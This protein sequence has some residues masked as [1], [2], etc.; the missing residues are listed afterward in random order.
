MSFPR[1]PNYKP[2]G[3]EWLGEVPEHWAIPPLYVRYEVV[4]GKMLDTRKITGEFLLPYIRNIDVQWD[5]INTIDLPEIDIMPDE[6]CRYTLKHGDLVVCEGGEVGRSA[7]WHGGIDRC[8]FQKAIHRLRPRSA[9]EVPRYLF[10]CMQFASAINIFVADGNPN[11][12]AHLTSEKFKLYRLPS[13]PMMEQYRIVAFLDQETAK[14][15]A[16][17]AE[18]QRLI[19]LLKE[20]RQAVI[21]H[22]VTKGL[23]PTVP[24]KPSGIE[25]LGDIPAH[26]TLVRI[27]HLA[28]S[29]EQGWSPQCEGFPV[30]TD[31][32]W[33]VL[34][35]GC[36]N[37]GIF[38][39]LEN[40]AL[41][42]ELEPVPSLSISAGDLLVSRANTR[43]LVGSSA[44]PQ[45]NHPNLLLCDKI[46]RIKLHKE[47][48]LPEFVSYYLGCTPVRGQIELGATGASSS[49]VNIGQSIILEL[50]IAIA[51]T[52]EQSQ[53]LSSIQRE[54][55]KL[56]TLTAEAERAIEL[57]QERRT[58]LISAAVTGQIDVRQLA[59]GVAA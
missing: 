19:E 2:S 30:E 59:Q 58:A 16:L 8:A 55:V 33:G 40:K 47:R 53:I 43:E 22:A 3:V 21:S 52:E 34:K 6:L 46:Y 56:G 32:E 41:P 51:S 23:D 27:K 12:I 48:V 35:V 14:I 37:G 10:F 50:S 36:V 39:P 5:R 54:I 44:V 45:R 26:W 49:M 24:M 11:T 25:W 42:P 29:I 9:N 15:D 7:I 28:C 31:T 38:N 17:V 13:P 4:L 57:L 1:Y 20:K 18:Q